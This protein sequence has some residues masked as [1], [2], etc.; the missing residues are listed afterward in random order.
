MIFCENSPWL[1]LIKII[2]KVIVFLSIYLNFSQKQTMSHFGTEP[3]FQDLKAIIKITTTLARPVI[4]V[5]CVGRRK[6]RGVQ[7]EILILLTA[8][9]S[10]RN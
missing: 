9:N 4:S 10:S 7:P 3:A 6:K 8:P 2:I 5:G 1:S